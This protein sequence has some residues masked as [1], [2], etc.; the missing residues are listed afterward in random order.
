MIPAAK[1]LG[2]RSKGSAAGIKGFSARESRVVGAGIK[3]KATAQIFML[4]QTFA[5]N[6]ST[7]FNDK[8]N[9]VSLG[10]QFPNSLSILLIFFI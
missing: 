6:F 9:D 3:G 7:R 2:S 4:S 10:Q 1:T 5:D 8:I